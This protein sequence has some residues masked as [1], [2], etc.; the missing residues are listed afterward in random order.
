MI[1]TRPSGVSSRKSTLL[2]S[3]GFALLILAS[4]AD[5][6]FQ[7]R[8]FSGRD[9]LA[10]NLPME[11]SIHDAYARGRLPVWSPHISGGRPLL[12]NPNAGALY[13]VRIG[14]S[15]LTFPAAVRVFPA[16]HWIAAGVGVILLLG[17]LGTSAAACWIA[18]VTYVFSGVV[19]SEAYFPHILPGMTYLPWILWLL[20]R[21]ARPLRRIL[22]LSMVIALDLLAADVFTIAVAVGAGVLWIVLEEDA[23]RQPSLLAQFAAAGGLAVLAAAPQIV[24]TALWIPETNRSVLGMRVSEAIL[25]SIRPERL[26]ELFIPFPFGA[27]WK[28]ETS[29]IW[30]WPVFRNKAMGLFATL[31]VGSL[32][33]MAVVMLWRSRRGGTRFARIAA[34][35]A[36][37]LAIAPSLLPAALSRL[38]SPIALR[39]P[40]K[41]AVL[42]ALG[43]AILC[44]Q[45]VDTVREGRR[46]GSWTTILGAVLAAAALAASAWPGAFAR[47]AVGLVGADPVFLPAARSLVAPALVEG[48]LLWWITL[49]ALDALTVRKR[50]RLLVAL[51]LLTLVPLTNRRIAQTSSED[52]AF[53][54]TG[55]ARRLR[56]LDP[57]NSYRTLGESIYWLAPKVPQ[58]DLGWSEIPGRKWTQHTQVLWDRGTVFN[59]DFDAGDLARVEGLRRVSA[60]AALSP[61]SS[62]FFGSLSLRWGI[63]PREQPPVPGYRRFGGDLLQDWDEHERPFPDLRLA[64]R[65]REEPDSLAAL[66][67][68]PHLAPGEIV[69]ETGRALVGSAP[70]GKIRVI[71]KEPESLR[72]ETTASQPTWLFVLRAFWNHRSVWLDGRKTEYQPAQLAFSAVAIP[73][74]VHRLEWREALPGGNVS[75]WGPVAYVL[76]LAGLLAADRRRGAA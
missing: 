65:W 14:L 35:A 16:L 2:L 27:T 26:L 43:L 23:S 48:A 38:R 37:A 15:V 54:P 36:G 63:R 25:F 10:Y 7:H 8:T 22:G 24:A 12:P 59:V 28:L 29:Q 34:V 20:H 64:T 40:E 55:F 18:A 70:P 46:A 72:L 9:L 50:W 11:K 58:G 45:A 51:A 61:D 30:G 57:H 47:A 21:P 53:A 4:Y 6:L 76:G 3:L 1:E 75:L 66:H 56:K 5:P 69:V 68:L 41:F 60:A 31:Y 33:P 32:A 52:A 19:V 73:A 62:P 17:S 71:E 44:G 42:I 67:A 39:N 49:L 13:P 74:G